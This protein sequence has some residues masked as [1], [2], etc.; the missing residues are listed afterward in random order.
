MQTLM[1][2][3]N[4]YKQSYT[5]KRQKRPVVNDYTKTRTGMV[6]TR[7]YAEKLNEVFK[8]C[9]GALEYFDIDE[10]ATKEYYKKV[11]I[12][13][14]EREQKKAIE[15]AKN[16]NIADALLDRML[17]EQPAK[18]GLKPKTETED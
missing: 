1:V 9:E 13:K 3:G 15:E 18:R 10:E 7:D 12:Q 11:E 5:D 16:S 6:I 8:N 17:G 2:V 14:E 4:L